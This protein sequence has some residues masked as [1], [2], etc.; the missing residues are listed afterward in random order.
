MVYFSIL[1]TNSKI[2]QA[3]SA[4]NEEQGCERDYALTRP[5]L[6]VSWFQNDE[7]TE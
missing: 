7:Q 1:A 6:P 2:V 5:L 3:E 4:D